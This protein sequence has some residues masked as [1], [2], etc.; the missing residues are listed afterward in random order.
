MSSFTGNCT[1]EYGYYRSGASCIPCSGGS[2]KDTRGFGECTLCDVGRFSAAVAAVSNSTCAACDVGYFSAFPG[3]LQCQPCSAGF[4]TPR[5]GSVE[6]KPCWEGSYS[7]GGVATCTGCSAGSMSSEVA[8]TS[9]ATCAACPVGS[10]S[11]GNSSMCNIC[12]AC[13][14]WHYPQKFSFIA[15][16]MV[17]VFDRADSRMRFAV[18]P[19]SGKTYMASATSVFVVDLTAKRILSEVA[20]QGPGRAWWF[21][22]LAASQLGNYLYAIQSTYVFRVDLDMN[23]QWDL[24]YPSSSA[25][26]VVEDVTAPGNPLLWIAQLDGVRSMSPEQALVVNSYAIIGSNYICLSPADTEHLYVTG[27]FGLKKVRKA[28]G[29]ATSLLTGAAYTVCS[30]TTDGAF[31]ILSNAASKTAWAYSTF[32]GGM[33]KILNNAA[34]SGILVDSAN[35]VLGVDAVGV[36]NISYS[37]KDSSTCSPGKFSQYSGLQLESHCE[38]CPIG[39]LC[40]GGSNISQCV[41]GTFS[42]ATGLRE[43]GQCTVCP[44]GSFCSGGPML[45]MRPLGSFSLL[46]GLSSMADCADCPAGYYCPNATGRVKCPANTMSA[47]RSSDLGECRCAPGYS[48][49]ILIVV[50]AEIRLLILRTEFT[51]EMQERYIT[52]IALAAGVAAGSVHIVSISEVTIGQGRRLLEYNANAVEVHT[53]IYDSLTEKVSDLNAHLRSQGLPAHR[54]MRISVHEEVVSSAKSV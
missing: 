40:P 39:S 21:A 51:P 25:T 37:E 23:A 36:R 8:A 34:V 15:N 35:I 4:H 9:S 44:A 11:S 33:T 14:Y 13:S 10:W 52:A 7:L 29:E 28:T 31:L 48:C 2:Y 1:C 20:I 38:V 43:Q 32:D 46:T 54:G 26:C 47:A 45:Q 42:A 22:C 6:C 41:P 49:K 53:S 3:Q 27:S 24:V 12:G 17:P 19:V 18:H 5:L 16:A 50:H 30:F